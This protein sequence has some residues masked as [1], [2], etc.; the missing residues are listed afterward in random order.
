MHSCLHDNDLAQF[1]DLTESWDSLRIALRKVCNDL[2]SDYQDL[3]AAQKLFIN[4]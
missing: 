2:G 4:F 1:K 3:G